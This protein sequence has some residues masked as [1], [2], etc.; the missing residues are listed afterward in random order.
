M[1][2]SRFWRIVFSFLFCCG[3]W[4]LNP[5][6]AWAVETSLEATI[7][8]V[9]RQHPEAIL[10][11]LA[12][13]QA[14][15]QEQ[16]HQAQLQALEQLKQNISAVVAQSPV[17][18]RSQQSTVTLIEFADYEC[19]F[20][21]ETHPEL[22]QFLEQY[23]TVELV[24]K[25]LPLVDIHPEALSAAKASWAALQQDKFWEFHNALFERQGDLNEQAYEAIATGLKLNLEQFEHD[26]H[27]LAATEAITQD[28]RLAE[29]FNIEGTPSFVVVTPEEV[30]LVSG[31]DFLALREAMPHTDLINYPE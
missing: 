11:S 24:Y 13:Y 21:I 25:H 23:P 7:L 26:R 3:I 19:P 14:G 17:L 22:Q 6:S 12:A 9:I 5:T 20:C 16:A 18:K 28:M 4:G 29:R 1:M 31:A 27:N 2:S 15:Q 8:E 30:E 10:E